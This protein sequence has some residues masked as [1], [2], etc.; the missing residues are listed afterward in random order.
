MAVNNVEPMMLNVFTSSK[1]SLLCTGTSGLFSGTSDLLPPLEITSSKAA[2]DQAGGVC[3]ASASLSSSMES[4]EEQKALEVGRIPVTR[5]AS[6]QPTTAE[7]WKMLGDEV[8][9]LTPN[10]IVGGTNGE[11]KSP[12]L[13]EVVSDTPLTT[14]QPLELAPT[15]VE[16]LNAEHQ[17]SAQLGIGLPGVAGTEEIYKEADAEDSSTEESILTAFPGGLHSGVPSNTSDPRASLGM[18]DP[19]A[20][21]L[22]EIELGGTSQRTDEHVAEVPTVGCQPTNGGLDS[23]LASFH[24]PHGIDGATAMETPWKSERAAAMWSPARAPWLLGSPLPHGELCPVLAE[25]YN[26][27]VHYCTFLPVSRCLL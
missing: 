11:E 2:L 27:G 4:V 16:E 24:Q 5:A 9:T 22:A 3:S 25:V 26:S 8:R 15:A 23:D 21:A 17:R 19:Y 6:N 20:D 13:Q 1:V 18:P 7:C 12:L 14:S 10:L